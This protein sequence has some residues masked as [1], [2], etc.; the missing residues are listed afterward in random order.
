[1]VWSEKKRAELQ[2]KFGDATGGDLYNPK[3]QR[4]AERIFSEGGRRPAPYAGMPTL[5]DAPHRPVD[6][7]SFDIGDLHVALFGVPMDLG[8]TNRNGAR[9]G[10]RALRTIERIGPFNDALACAPVHEMAV[11]DIGDVPMQSRCGARR[12]LLLPGGAAPIRHHHV[13]HAFG[14]AAARRGGGA[15]GG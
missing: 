8:V 12:Q 10:P 1:M 13:A 2:G 6:A 11:A 7:A 4:I 3:F 14:F 15:Q 5:L 9:F